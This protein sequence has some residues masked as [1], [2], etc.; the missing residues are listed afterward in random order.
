MA[1]TSIQ[2]VGKAFIVYGT[3]KAVSAAG[4]ERILTPN[5]PI[6]ADERI[7]TGPDGSISIVLADNHGHL[8][9][10]R[11]S[12]V[13]IDEDVY[14]AGGHEGAADAVAQ[15]TDIQAALQDENF[16]PT[17]DL[18]SPA[19]GAG[20]A[21]T[22]AR[23]GGR[24]I[25]VFEADNKEVLPDSGAETKGIVHTFLDPPPGGFA[26]EVVE[27]GPVAG[28]VERTLD[29]ANLAEGTHPDAVALTTHGTLADLGVNFGSDTSGT[30]DF[31]GG[32]SIVIDG[33]SGHSITI[34]SPYGNLVVDGTGAWNYTLIDNAPHTN[35]LETGSADQFNDPFS[36][37]V[38]TAHGSA[39]GSVLIHIND[40]GPQVVVTLTDGMGVSTD[41]SS[42]LG[43]AMTASG[44]MVNITSQTGSDG[45]VTDVSLHIDSAATGFTTTDGGHAITLVADATDNNLVHGQYTDGTGTHDA[46]TVSIS[47]AGV[48]SVTQ[49]VALVHPDHPSNYDEAISLDGKLSAVVTV[50]DGDQDVASDSVSIGSQIT[51]EDD[52]PSVTDMVVSTEGAVATDESS[53]LGV[54]VVGTASVFT[55]GVASLGADGGSTDVS[56]HIDS[57]ATGFTTTAGGYAITLVADATDNNLVHGQYTDS[58]DVTHDA[59]TVSISDAGVVSV[60][61][62]V[63]LVHPDHPSNYDEAISLDGKLSAVVTVTD[64]DQD[65]AS[66]SVSIGS[67]IT[68]E[69]DGPSVTDMVVSTE[70]AVATDESSQLGVTVV[71]TASVFTG[72]VASL[73]AD[74]GSTDVSL[75]IDSAATGF[76]TTAGGYA[77]T[78][79]ADA[80]DNNLVHGQYTDSSDVTH[81]AFTV[82]IS[83][84]GVV[85]VTQ[86][87]ALVHPDHPSNYDE[88]ISLDGKLSAV[89]TVTDGDQDVASDSVS[90]GSQITFEDDG[91]SVTDMVVSTE[92][93]VATDESSQLGVTVVGTASVFTGGV[94]SLGADGGST[95]VSLHI[96]SAATGFTTTAGGYA[97]TLVADATD[98]NLV[99]G[100]YT[101]SSDVTHDA[102]T[103]SISDAGVVSVTQNVA[104]VHP[105]HPSNYDEA[106]S[107]DG[108][109]SAVVTVTDGDQDVASDSVSIGSQI[110][111]EDDG[112][113]VTDMVVSTEG[114][115]A[116]DESSQLGVT[117]V[118]TASVFTGGVASLG[119]DGGSTDV[120]LHIDSAATGFTTTEGGYAITLVADA[121]DN[122][123]V[124][125]QYTDGT[126]I[127]DAFT[128][129]ISD[130]GV[131]SVTQNVALV[132][133]DHPSN[134]DEAISLDGKL[135][136]VVTV[137][138][139]DQD[140]A[141][142]SVSIGSQITFED[143]GPSVTDMVVSTEGAVATDESSQLGATVVGTA[144]VFTGGVAST[145]VDG[146]TTDVSLHIDSAATGFTTTEGGYAITL[147]ADATDNNLVHG[148]YTDGT[149]IHD[150]FTVSISDAGVVSVT[151]NVA[152]V[153][154]D[155]PSN[156]DEA[157][158]LDGKLSA[159]VTVTDGDQDVASD[160]VSIGSQITFEDDG[161]SVTDM[162]VSTEGAV[163]TDE[164]SQ[165]GA[166]VVG[167]ASVF[168]GGVASTGVDG[169][170]TDVSLHIDSAATGFTTTDG[171]HAITLV[172]DVT[173]NNLVHGQYTDGTGIHDAFTVSISDAGVVS[174]TQNVAL[175]HPDHPSNYDEAI[176]LD[177]KLSAVVTVTDGDQDVASDSVSIGSQITF[178]DDGPSV[179]DM[180]VSTEGAVATDESSQLGTTV[181]G[182]ASV[183]TGG[184]ASTGVDG[185]TTDVS[186]HIDSAATGFTTTE[187][188]YAITL[189]ADAT[190]LA[191]ETS[192]ET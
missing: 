141:S 89:V 54:T 167:T 140:V 53:Q 21:G 20:V 105:D 165:L 65:V 134:Y 1:T 5:S 75:H 44:S 58:S 35:A 95:D 102:F 149:G 170:T 90:I 45:G 157:I 117:V 138:D 177:G 128:V 18:P 97:I 59:F 108:K 25:V 178:E 4:V 8:D 180:V 86:N 24:Q 99:H 114:A 173:D 166:T 2:L 60:T 111:F 3:V 67:Q 122:N 188:G 32:H 133:P 82:S 100:Q 136:A 135:S 186:L 68:F 71:G 92:G 163:A 84:A 47:D 192:P 159:V 29:E 26:Q 126:G 123:L 11:M 145:G 31:G 151:Q 88:A 110:T 55:G 124:H 144:S 93:A 131:V 119:A 23:G 36:F 81:D 169:G 27:T 127:H 179:T 14:G 107:L 19:A 132:H 83:D 137:T 69:D 91:P 171:G 172:A 64:G 76:T 174:V 51:F 103:V 79:V 153:H 156:Y 98:N 66:D 40:D 37:S 13:L 62:N 183:F 87:V 125:G 121:T 74:G 176:S 106:I 154:P 181:V 16:D 129:S 142:D 104:L 85:S 39:D 182:T 162:V 77:I 43:V 161:P 94:A 146:G 17:T 184:V 15:V 70:G 38:T 112:P 48:V 101:D 155:H 152:L 7:V 63:A 80:T 46:F 61:Q 190:E 185:G 189:V 28:T 130:A 49:N 139:G 120:S 30:L 160:S 72:G 150:A 42:D 109:L 164:S 168:T 148:Q 158:S 33:D 56:L 34:S 96:D 118:G 73:G 143:D 116:T 57:A 113:S 9:L 10:G 115:V 52:G 187:G 50:T 78:L 6:Y 12:D 147:V 22:G 191:S 175:V 41:E